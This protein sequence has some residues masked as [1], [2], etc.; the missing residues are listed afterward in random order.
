MIRR[1]SVVVVGGEKQVLAW[2]RKGVG[3]NPGLRRSTA[4][5]QGDVADDGGASRTNGSSRGGV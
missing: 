5:V 3:R 4:L 1:W 2:R